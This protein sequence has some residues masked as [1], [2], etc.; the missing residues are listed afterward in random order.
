MIIITLS[1]LRKNVVLERFHNIY[2]FYSRYTE[3][4]VTE[5]VTPRQTSE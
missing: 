4:S 1:S 3:E 2:T 5:S